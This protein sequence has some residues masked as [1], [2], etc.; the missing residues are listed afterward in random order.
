MSSTALALLTAAEIAASGIGTG[1]TAPVAP[2]EFAAPNPAYNLTWTM[3]NAVAGFLNAI[4]IPVDQVYLNTSN[5]TGVAPILTMTD[6]KALGYDPA[7]AANFVTDRGESLGLCWDLFR[8]NPPL[9][10]ARVI[11]FARYTQATEADF[12]NAIHDAL[13]KRV[14]FSY[15]DQIDAAAVKLIT[16]APAITT[17]SPTA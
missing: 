7:T 1:A 10:A 13:A 14:T 11:F 4:G 12:T 6:A 8:R 2:L 17:Q 9:G 3:A 16:A 5:A 15:G